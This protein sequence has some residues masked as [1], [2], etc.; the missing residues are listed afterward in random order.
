MI[1]LMDGCAV[2]LILPPLVHCLSIRWMIAVYF[3]RRLFSSSSFVELKVVCTIAFKI[4][5]ET[6][7]ALVFFF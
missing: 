4:I 5:I 3:A 2:C 1:G 6:L 7:L